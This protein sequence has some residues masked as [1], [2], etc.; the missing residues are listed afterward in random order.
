MLD[1]VVLSQNGRSSVGLMYGTLTSSTSSCIIIIITRSQ[2]ANYTLTLM[3]RLTYAVSCSQFHR[4]SLVSWE[5]R[6]PTFSDTSSLLH[7]SVQTH[8]I[9]LPHHIRSGTAALRLLPPPNLRLVQNHRGRMR[10]KTSL[11]LWRRARS[12][13][14][15][16]VAERL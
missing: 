11:S 8:P 2:G 13:V 16:A 7:R 9:V 15:T 5:K 6:S 14:V 1:I 4:R 3:Y 10:K 12:K